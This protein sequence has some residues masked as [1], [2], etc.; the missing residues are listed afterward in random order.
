MKGSDGTENWH[1]ESRP[2]R[3]LYT[4]NDYGQFHLHGHIHSPN[5]G[6]STRIEGRQIDVGVDANKY[7]PVSL[8]QVES[9]IAFIL[10]KE[11]ELDKS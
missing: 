4:V 7:Y 5:G 6:K 9:D 10:K 11:K 8:S 3:R 2:N 1:G